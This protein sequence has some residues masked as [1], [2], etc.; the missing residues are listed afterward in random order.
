MKA[1]TAPTARVS[2]RCSWRWRSIQ[3]NCRIN[4]R[5]RRQRRLQ[6]CRKRRHRA[7]IRCRRAPASTWERRSWAASDL[8]ITSV[9]SE[10]SCAGRR[11]ANGSVPRSAWRRCSPSTTRWEACGCG[12]GDCVRARSAGPRF[13]QYGELGVSA[14]LLSERALDLATARSQ[15]GLELGVRLAAG[16]YASRGRWAPFAALSGEL[17]P[18]PPAIFALPAGTVGHTP[19]FWIGATA[20]VSL[21]LL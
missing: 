5:C 8:R 17:V 14:A 6:S 10:P 20:G 15:T 13:A 16:L 21:G 4:R 7:M 12:N 18:V 3:L 1:G 9:S 11:G 19:I 2:R